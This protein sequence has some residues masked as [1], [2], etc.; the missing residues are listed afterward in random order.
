MQVTRS[1]D[2]HCLVLSLV[3]L[4][5]VLTIVLVLVDSASA[6]DFSSNELKRGTTSNNI[7]DFVD[8]LDLPSSTAQF[9]VHE[10]GNSPALEAFLNGKDNDKSALT[11][12]AC[13]SAQTCLGVDSVDT[14]PV[15]EAEIDSNWFEPCRPGTRKRLTY[16]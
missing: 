16:W 15:K 8:S 4:Y 2:L 13:L 11:Q 9:L 14:T 3:P 1:C 12:L 5:W 6:R 10:L 7:K